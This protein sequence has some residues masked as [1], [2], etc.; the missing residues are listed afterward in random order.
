M[1]VPNVKRPIVA[2]VAVLLAVVVAAGVVLNLRPSLGRYGAIMIGPD[3]AAASQRA[4]GVRVTFVGVTTLL[5]SDGETAILTDGF[6]SRPGLFAVATR[7]APDSG[8]IAWALQRARINRLAA[9]IPVHSHYDHAMDAG[10]VARLTGARLVGSRSTRNIGLGTGLPD[11]QITVVAPGDTMRFGRFRVT[12]LRSEHARTGRLLMPGEIGAPLTPPS[13]TRDY[14][15]GDTYSLLVEHDGRSIL[16]QGSAGFLPGALRNVKADVVFLGVAGLG[17]Q[18]DNYREDLWREVVRNTGAR[19][20][21]VIHWDDFLRP[22]SKRL[23]P[24]PRLMDDFPSTMEFLLERGARD[25][26]KV[27]ILREWATFDPFAPA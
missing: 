10:I 19:R 22:L 7:F 26:V 3:S 13:S 11:A 27:R 9:V 12:W 18:S 17:K 21:Y 23:V 20:A 16:V 15:L 14:R 25:D 1:P 6:F 8:R 4:P 24:M 5:F 2:L